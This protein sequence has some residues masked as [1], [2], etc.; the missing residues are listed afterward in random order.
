MS[1]LSAAEEN[2]EVPDD[3]ESLRFKYRHNYPYRRHPRP[4]DFGVRRSTPTTSTAATSTSKPEV[5][6][7]YQ[8]SLGSRLGYKAALSLT[9]T[10]APGPFVTLAARVRTEKGQVQLESLSETSR[11]R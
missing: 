9:T 2:N 4:G 8:S 6:P 11:V 1:H 3:S 10:E 7:G 5:A